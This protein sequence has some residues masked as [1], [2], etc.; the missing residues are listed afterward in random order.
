MK[1]GLAM[2]RVVQRGNLEGRASVVEFVHDVRWG[3]HA[4]NLDAKRAWVDAMHA[5]GLSDDHVRRQFRADSSNL[6]LVKVCKLRGAL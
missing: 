3:T 1:W 4:T 6:G 5:T 2:P